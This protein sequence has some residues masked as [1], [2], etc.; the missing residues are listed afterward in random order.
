MKERILSCAKHFFGARGVQNVSLAEIAK[1]CEISENTVYNHFESKEGLIS[2]IIEQGW[3]IYVDL[4]EEALRAR[5][6]SEPSLEFLASY[7]FPMLL[8]D[9]NYI[10]VF[11]FDLSLIPDAE[12]KLDYFCDLIRRA[13][14]GKNPNFRV[15][16]EDLKTAV[17]LFVLGGMTSVRLTKSHP[18]GITTHDL[19]SVI[20]D[21]GGSAI[22]SPRES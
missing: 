16:E 1:A 20:K 21:I 2:A 10:E 19:M 13:I 9:Q 4:I 5:P 11:L 3:R 7:A 22:S 15:I 8:Q 14:L 18:L 6:K 17:T 12:G